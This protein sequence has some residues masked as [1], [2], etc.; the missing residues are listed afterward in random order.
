LAKYLS[1]NIFLWGVFLMAQ[2]GS[3]TYGHM[4]GFRFVSGMFEAVADPAFG[5]W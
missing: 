3:T 4:L 2:A 5:E 1:I